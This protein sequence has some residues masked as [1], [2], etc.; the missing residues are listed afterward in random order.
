MTLMNQGQGFGHFT[1]QL[2][3]AARLSLMIGFTVNDGQ[4]PNRSDLSPLYQLDGVNPATYPSTVTQ[5]P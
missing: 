3:P 4:F 1:Y 5:N 2:S